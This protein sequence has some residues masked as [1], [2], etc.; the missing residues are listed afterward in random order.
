MGVVRGKD[1]KLYRNTDDP[2][3][4]SPT[5]AL[6]PNVKDLSRNLEK[7]LADASIRGSSY[8]LQVTTQKN[9]SADFQMVYDSED[10]DVQA[11]ED[12]FHD[13][14][15]VEVLFLDG[16]ITTIGSKGLRIQGEIGKFSV[17]ENLADV[18]TVDVSIVPGYTPLNLPRRVVVASPGSVVDA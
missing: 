11:F 3:D 6:V 12:A 10:T 18:G 7:E 1:F 15:T 4:S 5:W 8:K 9:F 17:T 13:D 14:G 2:Y 16:P